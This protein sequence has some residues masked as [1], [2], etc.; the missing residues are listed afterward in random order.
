[1]P[2]AER[3]LLPLWRWQLLGESSQPPTAS[4]PASRQPP[5]SRPTESTAAAA[6]QRGRLLAD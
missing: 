2:P 6:A 3:R 1:M 5:A 4:P